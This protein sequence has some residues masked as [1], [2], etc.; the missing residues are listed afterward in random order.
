MTN[1]EFAKCLEEIDQASKCTLS[2]KNEKYQKNDNPIHNFE[3]GAKISGMTPAQTCWGYLTKHLTALRDKVMKDDFDDAED[4]L[5]KCQDSINYIKFIYAIG[6]DPQHTE[7]MNRIEPEPSITYEAP[8]KEYYC[9]TCGRLV[10][11]TVGRVRYGGVV[12]ILASHLERQ[13]RWPPICFFD[14]E[15]LISENYVTYTIEGE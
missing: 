5:E 7:R 8:R 2:A 4:L 14:P 11:T 9:K 1:D 10:L 13:H 12:D 3:E 6:M 15:T